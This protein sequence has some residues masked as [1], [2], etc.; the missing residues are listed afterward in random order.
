M[1]VTAVTGTDPLE[2]GDLVQDDLGNVES[3]TYIVSFGTGTGGQGT[4]NVSHT[5][6]VASQAM[7]TSRL[8]D[9]VPTTLNQAPAISA[10]DVALATQ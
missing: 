10:D 5:Q 2:E 6:T 9:D 3:G 1:T 7:F 4:Y 8:L